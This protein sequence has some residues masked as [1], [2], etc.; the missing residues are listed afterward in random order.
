MSDADLTRLAAA[1]GIDVDWESAFGEPM[2][3]QPDVLR[4]V[5]AALGVPAGSETDIRDG[6]RRFGGDGGGGSEPMATGDV[7]RPIRVPV[8]GMAGPARFRIRIETGGAVEGEATPAGGAIELPA[9]GDAGYHALEIG[10]R[11]ITLAVAPRCSHSVRDL[12]RGHDPRLWGAAVQL[13]TLRGGGRYGAGDFSALAE[14]VGSAGRAGASAVAISP[15]HAMFAAD[16]ERFSPYSP[17][18]RLF[19]NGLYCDPAQVFGKEATA[20]AIAAAGLADEFARLEALDLIDWPSLA[21]AKL[22]LFRHLY[23]NALPGTAHVGALA[24]FAAEGGEALR[25]HARYEALLCHLLAQDRSFTGWRAWPEQYRSPSGPAVD[26]FAREHEREVGFHRFIQWLAAGGLD[27]AQAA[28]KAAGMPVGLVADLAIGTDGGGSQGW[29]R[30]GEILVGLSA[31]APPD[32]LNRMGQGWGISAFS[33]TALKQ[34]GFRAFIE[35]LRAS[36]RHAGGV[37]IDHV[38]GLMRLW[39]VPD[40]AI[41]RDG[42]YVRFPFDDLLRLIK[43]ESAR[44]QAIVVGEDLGTVPAGFRERMADVAVLGMGVLWFEKTRQRFFPPA[45]WRRNAMAMTTTHDLPTVAGWWG[46]RDI[47]WRVRLDLLG[48]GFTEEG[49]RQ[50]RAGERHQLAEMLRAEGIAGPDEYIDGQKAV[51]GAITL[52][53]RTPCPLAVI[54]LEDFLGQ[55]EEPNLPGTITEHPNWRRRTET[56]AGAIF[57]GDGPKRRARLLDEARGPRS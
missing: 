49:E 50:A 4:T 51:D 6:L 21:G 29:T 19:L 9:I 5:L 52:V 14:F 11:E 57:D 13:Y 39:L 30:Q 22:T 35:M 28:A 46:E 36:F 54:P 15:V 10:G 55:V 24:R 37:R 53:G 2:T 3:T 17:S 31:G 34:T 41:P 45:E 48:A 25:D 7:G 32:L 26:R 20:Q 23:D 47:D 40:G 8:G 27:A 38:M 12:G 16:P 43:L 33:P 44:H 1:A 56:E 42:A 18:S